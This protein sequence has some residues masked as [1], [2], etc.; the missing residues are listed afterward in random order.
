MAN[1][2]GELIKIAGRDYRVRY[3]FNRLAEVEELLGK[4]TNETLTDIRILHVRDFRGLLWG[5]LTG[6]NGRR[7][8]VIEVGDLIQ[9]HVDDGGALRDL[10]GPVE[11][12]LWSA[13][14]LDREPEAAPPGN[15]P[16]PGDPTSPGG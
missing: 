13:L 6:S 4:H 7:L 3:N 1:S 9:K 10:Y 12:A 14:G 16:A 11:T 5:G 2:S 8:S 15:A